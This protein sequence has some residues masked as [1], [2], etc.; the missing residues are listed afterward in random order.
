MR[1][2]SRAAGAAMAGLVAVL[3]ASSAAAGPIEISHKGVTSTGEASCATK[4]PASSKYAK[5]YFSATTL[6]CWSC[7]KGYKRVWTRTVGSKKACKRKSPT[8]YARAKKRGKPGCP[9]RDFRSGKKCYKCPAGYKRSPKIR[10]SSIANDPKACF[11]MAWSSNRDKSFLASKGPEARRRFNEDREL[12]GR[13][14]KVAAAMKA[15]SRSKQAL[16]GNGANREDVLRDVG[17]YEYQEEAE[18]DGFPTSSWGPAWDFSIIGGMAFGKG[19]AAE[20]GQ[21]RQYKSKSWTVGASVGLDGSYEVG[22]WKVDL[23]SFPGDARGIVIAGT[24]GIG[25]SVTFWWNDGGYIGYTVSPS[26]GGSLEIEY[27]EGTTWWEDWRND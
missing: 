4:Y 22:S 13:A 15:D 7:P 6:S 24:V 20:G 5:A 21:P 25:L 17:Y 27:I 10:L 16:R 12:I 2:I 3:F 23:D 19:E 26:G 9:G 1:L 8:K 11:R 18:E 14:A